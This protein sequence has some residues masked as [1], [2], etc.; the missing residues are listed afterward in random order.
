M[1]FG[2]KEML[3]RPVIKLTLIALIFSGVSGCGQQ[4]NESAHA[5]STRIK[6][7]APIPKYGAALR[8]DY[9]ME[10]PVQANAS[11]SV[12][13]VVDHDYAGGNLSLTANAEDGID[14]SVKS[15]SMPLIKGRKSTWTIPFT[16]KAD[17]LYYINV[18]GS[19][20]ELDGRIQA[21]AYSVRV[22]VGNPSVQQKPAVKE[23]ILP[24]EET[25]S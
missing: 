3:N 10:K 5:K 18:L 1:M 21:R 13:I 22:D 4:A 2:D 15:A 23:V 7:H 9:Q 24:A 8:Y 19:V 16:T 12:T 6:N 20:T 11:H 25:I 14:L 17:G